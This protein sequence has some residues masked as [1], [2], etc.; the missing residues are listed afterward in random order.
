M[1]PV[2]FHN[3]AI[4]WNNKFGE[5]AWIKNRNRPN[6]VIRPITFQTVLFRMP[7]SED[8]Y[9]RSLTPYLVSSYLDCLYKLFSNR[10]LGQF[11]KKLQQIHQRSLL[12]C[13][14]K[15][16]FSCLA[17]QIVFTTCF[18][19]GVDAPKWLKW[20]CERYEGEIFQSIKAL[21]CRIAFPQD[22]WNPSLPLAFPDQIITCLEHVHCLFNNSLLSGE[23]CVSQYCYMFARE[24]FFH[25][26]TQCLS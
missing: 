24:N 23:H 10:F 13:M 15:A 14:F 9:N 17:S 5:P 18:C 19:F 1:K 8:R 7:N 3:L 21:T 25:L 22:V 4:K 6:I 16:F 11:R 12:K 2:V 20:K 26:A